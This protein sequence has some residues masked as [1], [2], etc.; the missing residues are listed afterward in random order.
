MVIAITALQ[1]RDNFKLVAN[2]VNMHRQSTAIGG[3]VIMHH[4]VHKNYK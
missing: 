3:S 1:V 2:V 4:E